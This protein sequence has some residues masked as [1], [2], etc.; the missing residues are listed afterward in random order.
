MFPGTVM[1]SQIVTEVKMKT[2]VV[3]MVDVQMISSCARMSWEN[4]SR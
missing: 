4:V 1:A 3:Q 2:F